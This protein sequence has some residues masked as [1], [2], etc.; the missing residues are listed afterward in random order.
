M[1]NSAA[2]LEDSIFISNTLNSSIGNYNLSARGKRLYSNTS[3]KYTFT[4]RND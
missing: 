2:Q 1:K 4:I 3:L